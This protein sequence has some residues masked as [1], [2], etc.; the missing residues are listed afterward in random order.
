MSAAM[1]RAGGIMA[2]VMLPIV[3]VLG[4]LI[5]GGIIGAALKN[6]DGEAIVWLLTPVL[7][8]SLSPSRF[9]FSG[10]REACSERSATR[11][12]MDVS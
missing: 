7:F 1:V 10:R 5:V 11:L 3:L 8:W 4:L 6:P 12:P 2:L 9:S